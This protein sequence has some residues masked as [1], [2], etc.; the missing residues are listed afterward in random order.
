MSFSNFLSLLFVAFLFVSNP[1]HTQHKS[2]V[3]N[4]AKKENLFLGTVI[5]SAANWAATYDDY[6]V[7]STTRIGDNIISV[8]FMGKVFVTP[9][10]KN[11]GP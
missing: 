8:G 1:S 3:K 7:V 6:Y 11:V 9:A 5:S 10:H 4:T 2:A